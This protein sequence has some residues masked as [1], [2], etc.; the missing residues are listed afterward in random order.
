MNIIRFAIENP[1]KVTSGVILLLLFGLLS[2]FAIPVQLTPDVDQPRITV[3]T[4]WSGASPQ[5]IE[6]EIIDRQEQKLKSVSGLKKMTSSSKRGEGVVTL[7]FNVGVD[8]D[9]ALQDTIE[10]INQVGSYPEEVDRPETKAADAALDSPIAWLMF[11]ADVDD[12]SSMRDFV[13][14]NVRPLLERVDGVAAVDIYGGREREVRVNVDASKMVSRGVSFRELESALRT[15]NENRTAGT[16]SQSKREYTYRTIGEFRSVEEVANTVIKYNSG[17]PIYVGD[18]AEIEMT[19]QKQYSFVRSVGEDVL[20]LPVRRESGANVMS[21]MAAL[22]EQIAYVND[23]VL[24]PRKENMRVTMSY[25]ETEYIESSI[26]LVISNIFFGGLLATVVLLIFL[27]STSATL[28]VAMTIPISVIGAFLMVTVLGRNLN[29]IM[30][31]GMAFAVGMVVDNAVV[32]LE[33]IYRHREAGLSQRDAALKG[34]GEVWGAILASTL[35]TVAV[36]LPVIFIEE[37]AGELFADIAIAISTAVA[38]SLIISVTV[39]PTTAARIL[40]ASNAKRPGLDEKNVTGIGVAVAGFVEKINR[41]VSTRLAVVAGLTAIAIFGS[42]AL[43]PQGTYLPNGNRNLVFGVLLCP[44]GYSLDEFRQIGGKVEGD[45]RPYWTAE[46]DS[47][48]AA[49]LPDIEMRLGD[50]P[51]ARSM[52]IHPP[53]IE[54]FFFVSFDGGA[55]MGC[56]SKEPEV[57][58][59]LANVLTT[60]TDRI[61]GIMA[62][63]Q[64]SSLFGDALSGGNV[65]ELE[66]RCDNEANLMQAAKGLFVKIMQAQMRAQ[67]KPTT[68]DL[69]RPEYQARIDRVKAADVGLNV[70]DVGFALEACVNGA[71]VGNYRDKGDEIDLVIKVADTEGLALQEISSIPVYTPTGDVIPL[72]SVVNFELAFEPQEITHSESMKSIG[73]SISPPQGVPLEAAMN[74]V[75]NEMIKPMRD[76]GIM[77]PDVIA[78]MEGNADKLVQTRRALV[79]S[80]QGLFTSPSLFGMNPTTTLLIVAIILIIAGAIVGSLRSKAAMLMLPMLLLAGLILVTFAM[81]PQLALELLQSRGILAAVVT[82]LL[83]AALFESFAYPLVIMLSVPLA[84]VGGFAGLAI[85]HRVTANDPVSPIQELDVL[86]MLGFII[87]IGIVV[88]NAILIVHQSL[89]N[90]REGME[91]QAAISHSVG[92]RVRPIFMTAL[93]SIGG[94]L[95]LVIMPGSGS[96]LYRGLGSVLVGGLLVATVFTLIVIPAMFS[97]FVEFRAMLRPSTRRDSTKESG[98]ISPKPALV[99]ASAAGAP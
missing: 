54:N 12:I 48:E 87:L 43:C 57:V 17:G 30:L 19:N 13:D 60:A 32:V 99:N 88:N 62:F 10:K 45:I 72:S 92:T 36:F 47:Q 40:R 77:Q 4:R 61:P 41:R 69:G 18:I 63:F 44:P 79:G 94:M 6:N 85:V 68:F 66:L 93:T 24:A 78:S 64:Q 90:M 76:E 83:M 5:E 50:G 75:Q 29:V 96:E 59:P 15:Q 91:P 56:S 7:E 67:P 16:I 21:T 3:T 23:T 2:F 84:T 20:A 34:T 70:S 71:Y 81:N 89:N 82:Y 8:K 55:F 80:Y 26:N 95:P 38:L 73:F 14:D 97:L 49:A 52:T 25:D 27:R 22:K 46:K 74:L 35:T 65:I 28:I 39:I 11:R 42:R 86:T 1:V 31:A 33:N 53:P 58:K 98:S 37:E 51:K 9:A